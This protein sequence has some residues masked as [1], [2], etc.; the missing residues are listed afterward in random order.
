MNTCKLKNRIDAFSITESIIV[1]IIVIVIIGAIAGN[2]NKF[3]SYLN[4]SDTEKALLEMRSDITQTYAGSLGYSDL[5]TDIA[6]KAKLVPHSMLRGDTIINAWGGEVTFAPTD[7]GE[8][9]AITFTEIPQGECVKLS[10][11]QP[12]AWKTVEINGSELTEEQR[13]VGQVT[14]LCIEGSNTLTFTSSRS[15]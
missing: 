15:Y 7:G 12:S 3:I 10:M 6:L 5:T 13:T 2:W 14:G 4:V 1:S 8:S 9:F 11:F